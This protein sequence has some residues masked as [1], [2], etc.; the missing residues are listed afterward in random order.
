MCIISNIYHCNIF[1]IF[2]N[3]PFLQAGKAGF[4]LI[5]PAG[6]SLP[7]TPLLLVVTPHHG[8]WTHN[9]ARPITVVH[10]LRVVMGSSFLHKWNSHF[11]TSRF[12]ASLVSRTALDAWNLSLLMAARKTEGWCQW[13][14]LCLKDLTSV[15]VLSIFRFISWLAYADAAAGCH[16]EGSL[17]LCCYPR[18]LS[19][20]LLTERRWEG[21]FLRTEMRGSNI[22]APWLHF[23]G[24]KQRHLG[25]HCPE[26]NDLRLQSLC[27]PKGVL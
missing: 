15:G 8:G 24:T 22:Q 3:L 26:Q 23:E 21:V 27:R 20:W 25:P 4:H 14:L 16:L 17:V 1:G 19:S 12:S 5:H 11:Y 2:W 18:R 9:H 10:A 7:R 13:H 6:S